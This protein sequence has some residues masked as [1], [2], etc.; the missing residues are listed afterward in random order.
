M[1]FTKAIALPLIAASLAISTGCSAKPG[2]DGQLKTKA[3]VKM[4]HAHVKSSAPQ[5]YMKPGAAI[6]YSHN[7]P[8]DIAAGQTVVFQLT[9]DESY[10]TGNMSV[11]ITSEGDV[12]VF[13]STNYANFDMSAGRQ[14]V[15]D[16]SVTV[17]SNGRHYLNVRAEADN[18]SGQSMPR[19]F[20]IPVQSGAN[21]VM[22]PHSKIST[23][24]SGENIIIMEADEV[25]Q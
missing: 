18:G 20:S 12:Q 17:G 1:T 25:I 10:D 11:N 2:S 15:M 14:H 23:L 24:P 13:P 4:D 8:G 7:L 5:K 21:K 22:K 6:R 9:L 16:V 19:I 3:T